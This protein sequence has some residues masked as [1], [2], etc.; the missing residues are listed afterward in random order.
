MLF[1]MPHIL[2]LGSLC[3]FKMEVC[4]KHHYMHGTDNYIL[5]TENGRDFIFPIFLAEW[6]LAIPTQCTCYF[7]KFIRP[8]FFFI[9]TELSL[10]GRASVAEYTRVCDHPGFRLLVSDFCSCVLTCVDA[11]RDHLWYL[12]CRAWFE[13]QEVISSWEDKKWACACWG[14]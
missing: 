7:K 13:L 12:V 8:W 11:A 9:P 1:W 2:H 4:K 6:H 3:H 10:N 5:C 14:I